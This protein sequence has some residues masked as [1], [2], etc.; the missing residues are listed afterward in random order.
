MTGELLL[1]ICTKLEN[2]VELLVLPLSTGGTVIDCIIRRLSD[3]EDMV[4]M[5]F[6]DIVKS[7]K[8]ISFAHLVDLEAAPNNYGTQ[9]V[10]VRQ[11]SDLEQQLFSN[12]KSRT[13]QLLVALLLRADKHFLHSNFSVYQLEKRNKIF[14]FGINSKD[15]MTWSHRQHLV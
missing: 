6:S 9:V 3:T 8:P 11:T 4:R 14:N 15:F 10:H 13:I 1:K 7:L 5:I 2:H 12:L